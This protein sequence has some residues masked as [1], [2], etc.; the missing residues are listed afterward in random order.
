MSGDLFIGTLYNSPDCPTRQ[1]KSSKMLSNLNM[2]FNKFE[3]HEN[4]NNNNI[5][6]T[7]FE[8]CTRG[9]IFNSDYQ[10]SGVTSKV[11]VSVQRKKELKKAGGWG[12]L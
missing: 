4:I 10:I 6:K 9:L 11:M 3:G 2:Y 8:I 12:V 7:N 1:P 5:H